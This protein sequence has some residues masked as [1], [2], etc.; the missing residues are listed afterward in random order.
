MREA[1]QPGGKHQAAGSADEPQDNDEP[2]QLCV[3]GGN[4]NIAG[5]EWCYCRTYQVDASCP[6]RPAPFAVKHCTATDKIGKSQEESKGEA[7]DTQLVY[8]LLPGV[9]HQVTRYAH[10]DAACHQWHVPPDSLPGC[11]RH[12]GAAQ[13]GDLGRREKDTNACI[14]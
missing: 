2:T 7:Q 10:E 11:G 12:C 9:I 4:D 3:P 5:Q 13:T 8:P 6:G 1:L 14:G